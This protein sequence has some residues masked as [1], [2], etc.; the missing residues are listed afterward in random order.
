[1]KRRSFLCAV[2]L[3][4]L[5][6]AQFA[7]AVD[8]EGAMPR[9]KAK[10]L[11]GRTFDNESTKGKVVLLQFWTTWCGY[12]RRE[13]PVVDKLAKEFANDLVVLAVN[14]GES[15]AKVEDYLTGS[16]R[17]VQVV[18]TED[19][20]L[21]KLFPADGF[22][23]YVVVDRNGQIKGNQNGAGGALALRD[24]LAGAG[25]RGAEEQ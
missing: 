16:P 5:L 20:N 17:A 6:P 1:M 15:K 11:S 10:A 8:P 24:L 14:A 12:C 19:T 21:A 23:K 25:L 4:A 3:Y 22:P 9:F 2:S 7:C 13:Q 18:L